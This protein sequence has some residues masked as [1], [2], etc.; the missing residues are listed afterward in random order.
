M[1]IELSKVSKYC[2]THYWAYQDAYM[3]LNSFFEEVAMVCNTSI[4]MNIIL[5]LAGKHFKIYLTL[6]KILRRK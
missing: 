1:K 4:V 2:S 6:G 3:I 5:H